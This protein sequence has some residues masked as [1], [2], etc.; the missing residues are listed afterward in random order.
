MA[1]SFEHGGPKRSWLEAGEG[2]VEEGRHLSAGDRVFGTETEVVGRVAA[3]GDPGLRQG[4]DV[5]FEH[6]AGLVDEPV[7]IRWLQVQCPAAIW[8]AGQE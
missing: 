1:S 5:L 4:M 7:P 3:P 8:G 2:P 6:V